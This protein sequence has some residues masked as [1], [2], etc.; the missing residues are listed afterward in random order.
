M[1]VEGTLRGFA[2]R[3]ATAKGSERLLIGVGSIGLA[4][5]IGSIIVFAAG[6]D[7]ITFLLFLVWG[8]FGSSA[9]SPSPCARRRC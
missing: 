4:L 3:M 5:F 9:T 8:A 1:S 7:P 2:D 6:Y